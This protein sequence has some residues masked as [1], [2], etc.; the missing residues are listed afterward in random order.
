MQSLREILDKVSRIE[1]SVEQAEKMLRLSTVDE[2]GCLAKLDGNRELRKGVPE[3]ILA[4]GKTPADVAEIC[5]VMLSH[6]GRVIVSR[7]AKN[8]RRY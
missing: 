7:C 4:D 2:L 8:T 3:I 6:N 1:L 5:Q